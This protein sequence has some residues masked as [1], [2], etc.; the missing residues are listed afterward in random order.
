MGR[1]RGTGDR[2]VVPAC[3]D[4]QL[5]KLVCN[6]SL[7]KFRGRYSVWVELTSSFE[8]CLLTYCTPITEFPNST[9]WLGN[10]NTANIKIIQSGSYT[11]VQLF[12]KQ[13]TKL[14]Q[15]IMDRQHSK[16]TEQHNLA[17]AAQNDDRKQGTWIGYGGGREGDRRT[18]TGSSSVGWSRDELQAL[19]EQRVGEH[20]V[21]G[22]GGVEAVPE[23]VAR[24]VGARPRGALVAQHRRLDGARPAAR[25][26]RLE[27]P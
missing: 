2:L 18:T 5:C 20:P 25:P 12:L 16:Q 3:P 26:P 9:N 10:G 17:V 6:G 13:R 27:E 1:E 24:G 21:G 23:D 7:C 14:V 22:V 8:T 19:Q 11:P 4:G 15:E